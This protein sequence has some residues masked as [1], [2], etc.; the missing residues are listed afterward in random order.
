MVC[1]KAFSKIC[2]QSASWFASG[3]ITF[4]GTEKKENAPLICADR[5]SVIRILGGQY[6]QLAICPDVRET[7]F[8]KASTSACL[9]AIRASVYICVY[10]YIY[11]Y[12]YINVR[13]GMYTFGWD[14][15]E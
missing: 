9:K 14:P 11:I 15:F 1:L 6:R 2:L 8:R 12:V 10:I 13:T 4:H 5:G 7:C 3:S